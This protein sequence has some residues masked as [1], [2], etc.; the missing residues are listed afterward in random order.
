M[1]RRARIL[2]AMFIAVAVPA[3]AQDKAL[4]P[5]VVSLPEVLRLVRE[6]SPRL[7]VERFNIRG[8]EANRIT[9]GA[10]P[11]PT[12]S[13]GQYRPQSG[14]RTLFDGN[15]QEQATLELPLLLNGQ[16]GARIE[17]ADREIEAARARV[18]SGAST[19][20]AESGSAFIA[21]LA[22]QEKE[23]QLTSALDEL[24]R[25]RDIVTKRAE[26]GA[27]S[28]YDVA[29][30]D[31]EVGSF[32]TKLAD[33][34]ADTVDRSGNLA[35]LLGIANWRPK[36]NGRLVPLMAAD[37]AVD[38]SP[39]RALSSPATRA[40]IEDEKVAHSAVDLARRERAPGVSLSAGRSW[41][42]NPF[43]AA[44]FLGLTVEL[45]LLD[46]RRGPLAKAEADASAATLRRE[47]ITAE[48]EANLQRY[49][50]VITARTAALQRFEKD[51]AGR[52]PQLKEMS[53]HAYRLGRGSIFELLDASRSR[54]ELYQTRIDLTTGLC[55]AQLRYL[56]I[57][58]DL[59]RTADSGT[60]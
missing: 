60:Q 14:Q 16:L 52:L 26:L 42:S 8:A 6:V 50:L 33:A 9:A 39:G 11:N 36:A 59:E 13:Y 19:L 25:L 49:A 12:L 53:E 41:T 20:A 29:R 27:A 18:A 24:T 23:L 17:K 15:R 35:A 54:H 10:Y 7:A 56:A 30:L 37:D 40:A 38:T 57:S 31:V 32:R 55:E 28:R 43:G 3:V 2:L 45:P 58:G 21:L 51:A 22:A 46:T 34:Q 44:N 48:I 4:P 1:K 47:L 5:T